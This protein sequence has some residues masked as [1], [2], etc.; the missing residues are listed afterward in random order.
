MS[1]G[2]EQRIRRRTLMGGGLA[3][4]AAA[5][6]PRITFAADGPLN[7]WFGA[8]G[9]TAGQGLVWNHGLNIALT[10]AGAPYG[11]VMSQGATIAS[12]LIEASGGPKIVL[13]LNDHNNGEVQA[14][15]SGVR[16]LLQQEKIQSLGCSY[17]AATQA[18]FPLIASSGLT[19]FWSGGANP[20]GI[21]QKDVWTTMA[22]YGVD[23]AIGA[24]AFIAKKFP[25]A[26]RLAVLGMLENGLQ[27]VQ[28]IVPEN[29]PKISGGEIVMNEIINIGTT[30]FGSVVAK[31]KAAKAD[32]IFSTLF[33]NDMGYMI[34]Q[35]R[36]AKI[37][38][39]IMSVD[40]ATPSVPDIAGAAIADECYL[41][42]DGYFPDNPNPYNVAF[43]DAYKAAYGTDPEYFA[44]NFFEATNVLWALIARSLKAGKTPGLG[45]LS[46]EI[47]KDPSF[48]S[49]YGGTA[50]QVGMMTFN[51]DHS[52][53]K[54]LG[55]YKIGAKGK[56]TKEATIQKNSTDVVML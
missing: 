41:A 3:A 12:K 39:P 22:L 48:P 37:T 47:D 7:A 15:V 35:L 26:K 6:A 33:A 23:P 13:K 49:V 56:L 9:T 24:L 11:Q 44:A 54:P 30:D 50:S 19:T 42:V 55:V 28:T 29:W 36:D 16:R 18:L 34:K 45:N 5:L 40:L 20:A 14:S 25:Q 4:I 10:G 38:A 27:A 17:G 31:L 52:V 53:V 1:N 21:N 46:E 32:V 8:G 2:F 43:V 51:K